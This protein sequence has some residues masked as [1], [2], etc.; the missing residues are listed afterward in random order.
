MN[1]SICLLGLLASLPSCH[2]TELPEGTGAG[3]L[4]WDR[5]PPK[6]A[7]LWQRPKL[8]Q[9]DRFVYRR[10]GRIDLEYRVTR[11]DES[12]YE[13]LEE[14]TGLIRVLTPDL[15]ETERFV[16]NN[17]AK[18]VVRA[19]ADFLLH[20]PL[21]VGKRWSGQ[22]L[23]KH[24]DGRVLP[25]R[26]HYRCEAVVAV[27]LDSGVTLPCL[28]IVRTSRLEIGNRKFLDQT[29]IL[30]YAPKL[31]W[32]ARRIADGVKSEIRAWHRQR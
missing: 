28:R 19:P 29:S 8:R 1:R 21:W 3:L 15:A 14:R 11:A 9:G 5:T 31:G 26:V 10:G 30:D 16:P 17:P 2:S 13:L 18:R 7:K 25:I 6:G 12:G 4:A 27:R 22:Y 20:F 24:P 32:F 23:E